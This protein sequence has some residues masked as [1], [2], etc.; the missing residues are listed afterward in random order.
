M[1]VAVR[2]RLPSA[3]RREELIRLGRELF[4]D[5]PYDALSVEDI[6]AAAGISKGLLYHYFH[7]KRDFYVEVVR[8][9]ADEIRELTAPDPA[10]PL[11]EQLRRSIV[12]YLDYAEDHI[13]GVRAVFEGGVGSDPEFRRIT[14]E[15]RA[16]YIRRILRGLGVERPS[17]QL[18]LAL[19]GWMGYIEAASLDWLEHRDVD[20]DAFVATLVRTLETVVA[21]AS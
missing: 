5:Q 19:R 15:L 18:R 4:A 11:R 14:E 16:I 21:T 8:S 1:S 13:E 10:Q 17:P 12:S 3:A 6:A 20:R 9:A 7:T 2:T